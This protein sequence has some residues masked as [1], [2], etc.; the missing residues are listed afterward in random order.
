MVSINDN[1]VCITLCSR[2]NGEPQ[3][4]HFEKLFPC[5]PE[6]FLDEFTGKKGQNVPSVRAPILQKS[7]EGYGNSNQ[8]PAP[9]LTQNQN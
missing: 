5:Y 1:A 7:G 4:V 6:L 9:A 2:P 3:H 8:C